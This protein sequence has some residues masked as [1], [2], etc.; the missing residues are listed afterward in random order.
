MKGLA[1]LMMSLIVFMPISSSVILAAPQK[2]DGLNGTTTETTAPSNLLGNVTGGAAAGFA[3]G[4]PWGAALGGLFGY[5][6][7]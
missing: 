7:S 1:L 6:N 5:A 3:I 4:G 2:V